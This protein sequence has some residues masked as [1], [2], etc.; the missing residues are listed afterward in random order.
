MGEEEKVVDFRNVKLGMALPLTNQMSHTRWALTFERMWKPP[1]YTMLFP[2]IPP[3]EHADSIASIRNHLVR[4]ALE[5]D[6]THM[7]MLDTDQ[8]YPVDTIIKLFSRQLPIVHAKV[9]RGYDPF[10]PIMLKG[11]KDD[12]YKLI[13]DDV[14]GN[15]GLIEVDAIGTGCVLYNMD[16]FLD[17]EYPWFENLPAKNDTRTGE[18]IGFCW[19][20]KEAGYKIYADCDIDIGHMRLLEVNENTYW[21]FKQLREIANLPSDPEEAYEVFRRCTE[22]L[23]KANCK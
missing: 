4:Q 21:A 7:L 12:G 18:D 8:T 23:R 15:G 9:H 13:G 3:G 10:D 14:W 22:H 11:N 6:C 17:I 2:Q 19:K 20:L 16:V 5:A 1:Q